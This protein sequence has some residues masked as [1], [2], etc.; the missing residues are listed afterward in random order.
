MRKFLYRVS[1]C[2]A[3]IV[4]GWAL[5]LLWFAL[6]I[7]LSA[8][9]DTRQTDAIVVFTGD[10]GRIEHG[11]RLLA[12]GRAKHLFI[13][14]IEAKSITPK[15]LIDRSPPEIASRLRNL[16]EDTIVF[17]YNARNTIGNVIETEEWIRQNNF[18]S[19]RLVTSNYHMPRSFRELQFQLPNMTIIKDPSIIEPYNTRLW[20][21]N[22]SALPMLFSEY[23]KTLAARLRHWLLQLTGDA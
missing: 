17:G 10:D 23:H 20:W 6:Q 1:V 9:D 18:H 7:P 22:K 19:I 8:S 5:G 3:A 13:S 2:L 14:S 21:L 12:E 15:W 4:T 11:L 16:K